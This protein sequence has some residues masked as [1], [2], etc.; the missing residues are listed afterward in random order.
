MTYTPDF[1]VDEK[2]WHELKGW[3]DHS[4]IKKHRLFQEQY[5]NEK[6]ILIDHRTYKE[7]ERIY[8]Y[9]VLRWEF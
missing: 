1:L 6:F 3:E 9:L 5:P 2:E 7:I 4:K 8:K